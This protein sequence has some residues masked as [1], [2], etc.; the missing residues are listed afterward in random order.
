MAAG[1][2]CGLNGLSG[3]QE[4]SLAGPGVALI[5][6]TICPAALRTESTALRARCLMT[7]LELALVNV[8]RPYW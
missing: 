4:G 1:L 2:T 5:R 3:T 6:H 7:S 8:A